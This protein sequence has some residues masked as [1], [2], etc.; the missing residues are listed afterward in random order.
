[1]NTHLSISYS[2]LQGLTIALVGGDPRPAHLARLKRAFGL[3]DVIH[4]PTRQSD[5]SPRCFLAA[6]HRPDLVLVV[7]LCGLSR[8]NHG[9][10]LRAICNSQCVPWL[11]CLH[12]PHPNLLAALIHEHRLLD[13]ILRR[14]VCLTAVDSSGGGR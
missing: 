4:C 2:A 13:P 6:L 5:P 1:M 11:N 14:R 3:L 9:K 12:V 7:W 10:Q 8:T